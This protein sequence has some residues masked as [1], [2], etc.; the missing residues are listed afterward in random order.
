MGYEPHFRW[1]P[2]TENP[3]PIPLPK[4]LASRKFKP[5]SMTSET[6]KVKQ[7]KPMYPITKDSLVLFNPTTDSD[8]RYATF[9]TL[10]SGEKQCC[11]LT[12]HIYIVDRL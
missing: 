5:H 12:H 3:A 6:G 2:A 11:P 7:I 10:F 1:V 9:L 8:A 4:T